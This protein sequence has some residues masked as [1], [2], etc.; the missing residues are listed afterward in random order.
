[1]FSKALNK[2]FVYLTTVSI[3]IGTIVVLCYTKNFYASSMCVITNTASIDKGV[4]T[5]LR[6]NTGN[7]LDVVIEQSIH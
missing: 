6:E 5:S 7:F 4:D 1:M 3:T 2:K